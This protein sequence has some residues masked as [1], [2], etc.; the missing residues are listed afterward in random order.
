M[1]KAFS[2][3]V[4]SRIM[5]RV[6]NRNTSPELEVRSILHRLGFR[7]RLHVKSLR[8]SPDIVLPRF[9]AVVFVHGCFWHAH[10]CARGKTPASNVKFWS[11]KLERN[12]HR[13][14]L[15]RRWLMSHGWKV[16]TIWQC[17]LKKPERVSAKLTAFLS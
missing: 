9:R 3:A 15:A 12:K 17:E 14:L 4:R 10:R 6:R 1:R 5:S 11:A 2:D 7:F 8:G 16:L 13:D